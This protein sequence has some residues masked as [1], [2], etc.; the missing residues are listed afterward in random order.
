MNYNVM[1]VD[2]A[3][4]NRVKAKFLMETSFFRPMDHM[5]YLDQ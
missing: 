1:V 3:V 4:S 5:D 2:T